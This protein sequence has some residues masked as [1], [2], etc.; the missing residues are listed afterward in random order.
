MSSHYVNITTAIFSTC[1]N[2]L[3]KKKNLIRSINLKLR[4]FFVF[5]SHCEMRIKRIPQIFRWKPTQKSNNTWETAV[6]GIGL[7]KIH[8]FHQIIHDSQMQSGWK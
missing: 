2:L 5:N 3:N 7:V 8:L 4:I 6:R 1:L